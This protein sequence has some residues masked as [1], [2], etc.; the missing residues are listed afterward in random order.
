MSMTPITTIGVKPHEFL[1]DFIAAGGLHHDFKLYKVEVLEGPHNSARLVLTNGFI[2]GTHDVS[3][4]TLSQSRDLKVTIMNALR[5]LECRIRYEMGF[6][7][8]AAFCLRTPRK[9]KAELKRLEK[10]RALAP[11]PD[12]YLTGGIEAI[13]TLLRKAKRK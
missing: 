1:Q 8:T 9:V 3:E 6:C 5:V 10:A 12:A 4:H 11:G 7:A 13:E 2:T